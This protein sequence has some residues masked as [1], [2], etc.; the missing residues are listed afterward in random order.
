[1]T[2]DM[3]IKKMLLF[4]NLNKDQNTR[5]IQTDFSYTLD[6]YFENMSS[7]L[8]KKHINSEVER[9]MNDD[10]STTDE[11][12]CYSSPT[13]KR[14]SSKNDNGERM[15]EESEQVNKT[16]FIDT[17]GRHGRNRLPYPERISM[18]Q[19]EFVEL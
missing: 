2:H 15:N 7:T 9:V 4:S 10:L 3:L 17:S 8:E 11:E 16:L 18:L 12:T 6:L 19:H 14:K 13:T 1:M 5:F